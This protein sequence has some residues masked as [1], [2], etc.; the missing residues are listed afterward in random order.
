M[1][2]SVKDN[3]KISPSFH[4]SPSSCSVDAA[5]QSTICFIFMLFWYLVINSLGYNTFCFYL[6]SLRTSEPD[7]EVQE[8]QVQRLQLRLEWTQ[9]K[10][11][12]SRQI[13]RKFDAMISAQEAALRE[14]KLENLSLYEL[15][16]EVSVTSL[17]V[18]LWGVWIVFISI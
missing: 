14:L 5:Q 17:C 8:E 3:S 7:I 1:L 16:V 18:V 13:T 12:Q 15:A 4:S 11:K 2:R 10:A 6:H 9:Y